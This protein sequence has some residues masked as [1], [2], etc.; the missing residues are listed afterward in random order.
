MTPICNTDGTVPVEYLKR[1]DDCIL[2]RCLQY[3]CLILYLQIQGLRFGTCNAITLKSC[4]RHTLTTPTLLANG[5]LVF[6]R[7][8]R[9]QRR[10]LCILYIDSKSRSIRYVCITFTIGCVCMWFGAYRKTSS[11]NRTKSPNLNVSCFALQLSLPNP[12]KPDAKLRMKM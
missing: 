12:L 3:F 5:K 9:I 10:I 8:Y 11:I 1:L 4:A 7:V 2:W 6:V